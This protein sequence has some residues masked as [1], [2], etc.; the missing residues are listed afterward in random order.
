MTHKVAL[1]DVDKTIIQKDSM[2]QF[3]L[4]GLQ[5]KPS[6]FYLIFLI[7]IYS[8][9]YKLKWMK[10][11]RAKSSY[12]RFIN[13]MNEQDLEHFFNT[14]VKPYIYPEAL[15]EMNNKKEDGYHILLVTASPYAYMKYFNQFDEVDGVIGTNLVKRG[16]QFTH[17]IAGNNCKGQEKVTRIKSYLKEKGIMIDY[18]QSCAYS[19][20][21]SDMPMLQLVNQKYM[22]NR[23]KHTAGCE[24]LT[25]SL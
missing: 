13:Y 15:M 12:F 25:W 3:L 2:F 14:M 17:M 23:H 9:F 24:G 18:D 5:K 7:G 21:V 11:E 4:F 19:D 22:I 16:E 6:S 1:F 20:S 8:V 10:A